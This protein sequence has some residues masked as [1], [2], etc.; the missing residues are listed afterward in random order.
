MDVTLKHKQNSAAYV[1][2]LLVGLSTHGASL[3][4]PQ[5]TF[6]ISILEAMQKGHK[7]WQQQ[8]C[9]R[10]LTDLVKGLPET[11]LRAL[12]KVTHAS[13]K[14]MLQ[15]LEHAL[16]YGKQPG[17]ELLAWQLLDCTSGLLIA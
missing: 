12:Q 15:S 4:L 8:K 9:R 13:S 2:A 11:G 16:G 17:S 5:T 14:I 7:K 3:R 10:I 1:C 6:M